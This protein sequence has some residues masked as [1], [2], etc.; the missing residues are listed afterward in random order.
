MDADKLLARQVAK[1]TDSSGTLDVGALLTIIRTEYEERD[2]DTRRSE[3]ASRLMA[4]ELVDASEALELQN[5]R[6]KAALDN[7]GQGLCLCNAA[8]LVIV[9]NRR[10]LEIYG[11]QEPA[12]SGIGLQ[13]LLQSVANPKSSCDLAA[14]GLLQQHVNLDTAGSVIEQCWPD[15]RIIAI[16][17]TPVHD[18]G[19]LDT[20]SDVTEART[21]SARIFHLARHDALTG[22]PN[23]TLLRERMSHAVDQSRTGQPSAVLC[24]DLDRFKPINDTLGHPMGDALLEDVARRLVTLVRATDT[25]ARMGGDEFAIVLQGAPTPAEA[26]AMAARVVAELARPFAIKGHQLRIGASVGVAMITGPDADADEALRHADLALYQ[27]KGEGRGSYRSFT[28]ALDAVASQK[29]AIELELRDALADGSI[30]VHYQPQ[31]DLS[32]R[33]IRCFE[34]LVRWQHAV[35]G[36]V[37][38]GEFVVIAEESGLIDMLGEKVLLTACADATTWPES[39]KVAVNLSALQFASGRLVPLVHRALR[40]AGLPPHRLEL[41]VTESVLLERSTSVLSQLHALEEMGVQIC[42]DDFGIGYSSL[43]YIRTFPFDRVK[44]DRSFI[45]GL[46]S[47]PDSLAIVRAV[48]GLCT[49]LGISTTAEGVETESQLE[50]VGQEQCDSVQGLLFSKPVPLAETTALVQRFLSSTERLAA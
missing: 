47:A 48:T 16:V 23:R 8:G 29:R 5:L 41:E 40:L 32:T 34:A 17:R 31:L 37:L 46:G 30:V 22:L 39:T 15:G 11:L 1:S 4:E 44:I 33:T 6:F 45:A 27:A 19:F 25:V 24:L 9:C 3:R 20:I 36:L 14:S 13:S 7:M 12:R 28:N 43:A 18:G 49:S 21:A 2:H 35:R 50:I 10:F 26:E 42:L 38:P